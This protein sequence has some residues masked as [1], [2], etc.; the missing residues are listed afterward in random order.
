MF[1]DIYGSEAKAHETAGGN[2][3]LEVRKQITITRQDI[4]GIVCC[5][6]EGGITYWCCKAEVVEDEYYGEY[7]SEQISRGGSLRMH[8]SEDDEVYVLTLD[9]FLNGIRLA[10]R[11]GY[12]DEWFDGES[13]D[14]FRID[15]EAADI[16]VQYALF[17]EV[18]FG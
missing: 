9:K 11:D 5:A 2:F 18:M 17:G 7:A 1:T 13:L 6:L 16:I 12:G 3:A 10:C 14:Y 8:D 15:G 4:D